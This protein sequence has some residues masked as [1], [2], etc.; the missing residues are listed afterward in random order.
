M[1]PQK[2]KTIASAIDIPL[3]GGVMYTSTWRLDDEMHPFS[4]FRY[5]LSDWFNLVNFEADN[6]KTNGATKH[7]KSLYAVTLSLLRCILVFIVF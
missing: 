6:G 7:R 5:I 1:K 2:N 3:C 4:F